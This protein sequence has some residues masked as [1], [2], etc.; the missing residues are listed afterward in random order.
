MGL[1]SEGCSDATFF[2]P[3]NKIIASCGYFGTLYGIFLWG[4][5]CSGY[6][7]VRL[8]LHY[9]KFMTND[10]VNPIK[11]NLRNNIN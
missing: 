7:Y 11:T 3:H 10:K 9:F 2:N 5:F 8:R 4:Y 6:Y 1:F